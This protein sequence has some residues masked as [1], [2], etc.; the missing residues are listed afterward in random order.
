M[1]KVRIGSQGEGSDEM[2]VPRAFARRSSPDSPSS[3]W[4]I[5]RGAM[6]LPVGAPRLCEGQEAVLHNGDGGGVTTAMAALSSP[7]PNTLPYI[8]LKQSEGILGR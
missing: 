5:L 3:T 2:E 1:A 8:A 7:K 6:I 4:A